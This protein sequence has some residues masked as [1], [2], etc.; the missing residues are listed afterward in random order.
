LIAALPGHVAQRVLIL[1]LHRGDSAEN[2]RRRDQTANHYLLQARSRRFF[3]VPHRSGPGA[4]QGYQL[5]LEAVLAACSA[6]AGSS[7]WN[8]AL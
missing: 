7:I 8:E 4:A 6:A 5:E 3:P 2:E 1:G